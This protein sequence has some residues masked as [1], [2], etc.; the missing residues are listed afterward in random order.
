[1]LISAKINALRSPV[2]T[3]LHPSPS[4]P[5]PLE[6]LSCI[7]R[8]V[9][10]PF[11]HLRLGFLPK[12]WCPYFSTYHSVCRKKIVEIIRAAICHR[13][14]VIYF[15]GTSGG[16]LPQYWQVKSSRANTCHLTLAVR[17]DRDFGALLDLPKRISKCMDTR[18]TRYNGVAQPC[19]T[20]TGNQ[21]CRYPVRQVFCVLSYGVSRLRIYGNP[22][23]SNQIHQIRLLGMPFWRPYN[24]NDLPLQALS[25]GSDSIIYRGENG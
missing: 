11:S 1:M 25:A 16:R 6:T 3:S 14:S 7:A 8:S 9:S 22:K 10:F 19:S 15:K 20:A 13:D 18:D 23:Q 24:G 4:L 2:R 12:H 17:P 5:F 21:I